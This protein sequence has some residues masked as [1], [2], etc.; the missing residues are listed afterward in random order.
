MDGAEIGV[1]EEMHK[2]CLSGFLQR[3]DGLALESEFVGNIPR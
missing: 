2:E 1:F 3:L